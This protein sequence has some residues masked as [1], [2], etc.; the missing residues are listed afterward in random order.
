VC[1]RRG[2]HRE[3]LRGVARTSDTG[4]RPEHERASAGI[5][6][7]SCGPPRERTHPATPRLRRGA[8]SALPCLGWPPSWACWAHRS[9]PSRPRRRPQAARRSRAC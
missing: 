1:H 5:L 7:R 6:R 8:G 3:Q 9:G 4:L 2:R